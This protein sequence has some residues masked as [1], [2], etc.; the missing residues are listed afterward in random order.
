M[1]TSAIRNLVTDVPGL[2]VGNAHDNT[3]LSGVTV[4][5]G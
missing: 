3:L 2:R 4:V 5:L 1:P